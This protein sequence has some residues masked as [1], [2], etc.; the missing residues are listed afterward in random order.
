M[1]TCIFCEILAERVE[2]SF[3]YRDENVS[4]FMD[5]AQWTPG[6]LLIVPNVHAPLLADLDPAVGGEI[7]RVAMRIGE[8]VRRS[9]VSPEGINLHLA[10]GES[11]GQEIFHVH[12]HLIPRRRGDGFGLRSPHLGRHVLRSDLDHRADQIQTVL[13]R[14]RE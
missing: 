5:I 12:L 11:A 3:I 13:G 4:A 1:S 2:G 14:R 9:A 10:D 8:A 7:F 6:H